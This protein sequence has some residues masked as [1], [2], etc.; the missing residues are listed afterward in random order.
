M[1][2]LK[3]EANALILDDINIC[4]LKNKD[5]AEFYKKRR[6]LIKNESGEK[7]CGL[8]LQESDFIEAKD[9]KAVI[10]DTSGRKL[11]E[12]QKNE[13][14]ESTI[15]PDHILY[16]KNKNKYF[17]LV[18]HTYPYVLEYSYKLE[19]SS[20]FFWPSW[21]P[22]SDIPI[23]FSSYKLI[24]EHPVSYNNYG[25]GMEVIPVRTIERGDS[26][27]YWEIENVI[28]RISED[29]LPPENEIQM[30]LFFAPQNFRLGESYGS[31]VNWDAMADWYRIMAKGSYELSQEAKNEVHEL[32]KG[33][34]N[35]YEKTRT[36]YKYL[37]EKTRYAA[38]YLDIGGWQ[39][40]SAISVHK[41][42]Y[43]DCKDLTTYMVAMLTEA[44]IQAYPALAKT[45]DRGTVIKDFPSNQF[46][47]C[48]AFV[49]FEDDTLW[50][51]CT[52]DFLDI[53]DMPYKIEGIDALVI[54]D[55]AGEMIQTPVAPSDKNRWIS[56]STAEIYLSGT[57][58]IKSCVKTTGKQKR[59]FKSLF[60]YAKNDDKKIELQK[61]FGNYIPGLTINNYEFL[62]DGTDERVVLINFDG[63]Y[64][65]GVTKSGSR[66]FINP[67][68]FNRKTSSNIP[69]EDEDE[70]EFP[71]HFNYP[72]K[73]TDSVRIKIPYGYVL[74]AAP[75][76]IN[77]DN[78]FA[79]FKTE[80]KFEDQYLYFVRFFE[81]K[82]N[83]FSRDLYSEFVG[84]LKT[85]VKFDQT[86]FVF[87]K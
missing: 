8:W 70:R 25:I 66:L 28:P 79:T 81:Y 39:P 44:G 43:G 41:N 47:H 11:R 67:N 22:Q 53:K 34:D 77:I 17:E 29:F 84:F 1:D 80:F 10:T 21:Y 20:L 16:V 60:E 59:F 35:Q 15:S 19:L 6:I 4:T 2:S 42:R 55:D 83:H 31:F 32:I 46:N 7:Y 62:E 57:L 51:E 26:V 52:A 82:T 65:K 85:V 71:I 75:E 13:I 54:K 40:H 33:L 27:H 50:L 68:I 14:K 61:I 48:I 63:V 73:D 36:L 86:K 64:E 38:I 78:S 23:L 30:A 76:M 58:N 12:L 24:L 3:N 74:E 56:S 45:R 69:D 87:K 37:Q 72:Y 9:I 18:Y 5:A 49:P